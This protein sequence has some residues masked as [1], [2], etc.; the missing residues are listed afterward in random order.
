MRGNLFVKIFIGFWIVTCAVLG[1]WMLSSSY[2]EEQTPS[3]ATG[4]PPHGPPH[5]FMLRTLYELQHLQRQDLAAA[6]TRA[7]ERH[8]VEIYLLREDGSEL[9][10]RPVPQAVADTAQ[11]LQGARRRVFSRSPQGRLVG[12]DIY[13]RDD[14]AL[15]AV[16]LF[17]PRERRLLDLLGANPALRILL[18]VLISGL[19]CYGLSRLMTNRLKAL[20]L[21]SR[22]LANGELDTRLQVRERGGDETDELARD[23]NSMAAQLAQRIEAQKRLLRDVSHELRS[24]LARLRIALALAQDDEQARDAHLARIEQEI[25]RLEELIA[26]LLSSEAGEIALDSHVDLVALLRHLVDDARYEAGASGV[27]VTLQSPDRPAIVATSG[28]LLHKCFEN[29]LRNALAHTPGGGEVRVELVAQQGQVVVSIE[30]EGPGVPG[31]DLEK[32]FDAFYRVDT[33]RT[34]DSGG[35]GLGLSIARRAVLQHGGGV[36]ATNT[37]RGLRITVTLPGASAG[38]DPAG[39]P[40]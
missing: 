8:A 40:M 25:E 5:R 23:F 13:R 29:S 15:R 17:Q 30:D 39:E 1:S 24:P 27:E 16:F 22:R 2:F 4:R 37:D 10:G 32:I 21:A 3:M 9:F 35:Y 6:L 11:E 18:A 31:Q 28:D 7:R 33:A 38:A 34:R 36:T 26:Q 19:I 14:G 12:H 20:Q